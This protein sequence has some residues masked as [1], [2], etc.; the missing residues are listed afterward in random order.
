A[1]MSRGRKMVRGTTI[2]E[3]MLEMSHK[4]DGGNVSNTTTRH[5]GMLEPQPSTKESSPPQ[6]KSCKSQNFPMPPEQ[7]VAINVDNRRNDN[8]YS[9][10][11]VQVGSNVILFYFEMPKEIVA[12]GTLLSIDSNE[13]IYE[14]ALGYEFVKVVIRKAI[15][16]HYL[17]LRP[18]KSVNTVQDAVGKS[19]AWSILT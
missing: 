9:C 16:P 19:V 8:V 12:E 5:I 15:K 17:L 3:I 13:K 11:R 10:S 2:G 6:P 4:A 14:V 18:R 1:D 7:V